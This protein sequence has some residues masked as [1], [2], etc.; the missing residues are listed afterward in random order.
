MKVGGDFIRPKNINVLFQ[1]T[2]EYFLVSVGRHF[3]YFKNIF[4]HWKSI[5]IIQNTLKI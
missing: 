2:S 1:E 3:F 5:K 4:L